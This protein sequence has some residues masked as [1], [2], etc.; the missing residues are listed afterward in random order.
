[1]KYPSNTR[2]NKLLQL[3]FQMFFFRTWCEARNRQRSC[4]FISLSVRFNIYLRG[5]RGYNCDAPGQDSIHP[6][7]QGARQNLNK[8]G[9]GILFVCFYVVGAS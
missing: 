7:R 6:T 5:A 2:R 1:M 8:K 3:E 9:R 4:A